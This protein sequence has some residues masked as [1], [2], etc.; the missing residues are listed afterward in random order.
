MLEKFLKWFTWLTQLCVF[1]FLQRLFIIAKHEEI[2]LLANGSGMSVSFAVRTAFA[3]DK[4]STELDVLWSWDSISR[5][6]SK[7]RKGRF[8]C[9]SQ[10]KRWNIIDAKFLLQI[11][12]SQIASSNSMQVVICCCFFNMV[13]IERINTIH[14]SRSYSAGKRVPIKLKNKN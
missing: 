7:S 1:F 14:S 5:G 13:T 2:N 12:S 3:R 11:A 4:G 10:D 8:T 6:S 9:L